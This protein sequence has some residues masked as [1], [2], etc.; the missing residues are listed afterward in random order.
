M[1]DLIVSV[2]D[3][4]LSFYFT[5]SHRAFIGH[6]PKVSLQLLSRSTFSGSCNS[7]IM[8]EENGVFLNL[9]HVYLLYDQPK[10]ICVVN[11]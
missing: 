5:S 4:C 3:R 9:F 2:L 1:W 7:N 6:T 10:N 8:S 11:V